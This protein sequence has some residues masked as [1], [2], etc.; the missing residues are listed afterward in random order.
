VSAQ[1]GSHDHHHGDHH[2][3]HIPHSTKALRLA[4]FLNLSFTLIEVAGGLWT[5]SI[6]ILTDALHD[7]GDSVVLGAAWYLQNLA[8]RGRDTGYS[9]GYGR[10]SMLGGWLAAGMLIIGSILVFA[11]AIPRLFEPVLPH[12]TG[13]MVIGVFGLVMNSIAAW[14]LHGGTSLNERG[15]YLHLLEDVLGWA[16]V[17]IGAVI[18][19][20]TGFAQLD[21]LLS[22][23]ISIY[24]LYNAVRTLKHGTKILM[25]AQPA[26]I[27]MEDV[28][29]RLIELPNVIDVHDQH[30]WSL[31]GSYMIH[32]VHLVVQ[33]TDLR[34]AVATKTKARQLLAE[35]GIDHATIEL[36]LPDEDCGLE[37]H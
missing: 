2:H 18:M 34:E 4:F 30:I 6:A 20:F 24:I 19:H 16:A 21:P 7:L 26:D 10:Y 1:H 29:S 5:N 27:K 35:M 33:E 15:A 13:M 37:H 36:E 12:T 32:T 17:L 11:F 8:A 25:Q 22:M 23:A 28:R 31:D 3:H 14:T 9:Y